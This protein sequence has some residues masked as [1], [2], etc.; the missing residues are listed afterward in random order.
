MAG[1][2]E[3]IQPAN[4]VEL[5]I[6]GERAYGRA[7]G[8]QWQEMDNFAGSFAPNND[9]L[10]YLAGVKN[11]KREDMDSRITSHASR[12]TFALDGPAFA[13]HIRDQLEEQLRRTGEL[14]AGLHLDTPDSCASAVGDGEVWI[15][16]DGLP[17]RLTMHIEYPSRR[18]ANASPWMFRRIFPTSTRCWRRPILSTQQAARL[19]SPGW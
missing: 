19:R 9:L 12:F 4:S 10:A 11:V 15:D 1:G 2:C 17:L 7:A 5:R 18:A 16:D 13:D 14:P 3:H 8:G 6:E